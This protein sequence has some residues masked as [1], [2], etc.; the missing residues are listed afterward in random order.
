[1]IFELIIGDVQ[2]ILEIRDPL[3]KKFAF[4]YAFKLMTSYSKKF[5]GAESNYS[6]LF[7]K[8]KYKNKNK[9]ERKTFLFFYGSLDLIFF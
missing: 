2:Y 3:L 6:Y 1:M 5:H 9:K 4:F 8:K 7:K